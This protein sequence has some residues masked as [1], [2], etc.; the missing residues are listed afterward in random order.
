M[1]TKKF[2]QA[3]DIVTLSKTGTQLWLSKKYITMF[4]EITG[5]DTSMDPL[6]IQWSDYTEYWYKYEDIK[7][8]KRCGGLCNIFRGGI[9]Q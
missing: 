4:G 8:I 2:F 3:G 7:L 5:M 6:L 9:D 1:K